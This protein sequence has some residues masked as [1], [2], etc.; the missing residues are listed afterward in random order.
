MHASHLCRSLASPACLCGESDHLRLT[1]A[2]F[3]AL[4]SFNRSASHMLSSAPSVSV[5]EAVGAEILSSGDEPLRTLL[6]SLSQ[7]PS[8]A[9]PLLL[10]RSL[11]AGGEFAQCA[12]DCQLPLSQLSSLS[13]HPLTA[14]SG[15]MCERNRL[16]CA[17]YCLPRLRRLKV[18]RYTLCAVDHSVLFS[19]PLEHLDLSGSTR[20]CSTVGSLAA[21]GISRA[22]RSLLLEADG[23]RMERQELGA[24][25]QN[26]S[27]TPSVRYLAFSAASL[28]HRLR[29][30]ST[31]R[32]LT[33]VD[34]SSSAVDKAYLSFFVTSSGSPVLPCLV[35]FSAA[36]VDF[37][38]HNRLT[39]RAD[40][41]QHDLLRFAH[42]YRQ[43]HT[44][45]L[46]L[47]GDELTHAMLV[48]EALNE[49]Q[50]V[51]TFGLRAQSKAA[52]RHDGQYDS[53][54]EDEQF[55]DEK[56]EETS[57]AATTTVSLT[58][59]PLLRSLRWLADVE[60]NAVPLQD[61]ALLAVLRSCCR[62]R[63]VT[64]RDCDQQTTAAWLL[65]AINAP[66]LVSLTI[67]SEEVKATAAAWKRAIEAFPSL[68]YL[69][70]PPTSSSDSPV[71]VLHSGFPGLA[72][73]GIRLSNAEQSD[74]LGFT[75]LMYLMANAPITALSIHL[76]VNAALGARIQQLQA[77][78]HMQSLRISPQAGKGQADTAEGRKQQQT[79]DSIQQLLTSCVRSR[80]LSQ[81]QHA[82]WL[83][84]GWD[85]ER[86]CD[87]EEGTEGGGMCSHNAA[88]DVL[89][90]GNEYTQAHGMF[91]RLFS[92]SPADGQPL[93][94]RERFFDEL[95]GLCE[96]D[97][98]CIMH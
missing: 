97:Q 11:Y 93:A 27:H 24:L 9:P 80:Q 1:A 50:H 13:V 44:C 63:R 19:L 62:L 95:R 32:Q 2:V 73:L 52:I 18:D 39:Q 45:R 72:Q 4:C 96:A 36:Q 87:S 71:P 17:L 35:Y 25:M 28:P 77:M 21:V 22:L 56:R 5:D 14:R 20:A 60:L 54:E 84:A 49:L 51:R 91:H 78:S 26:V 83:A 94:G 81:Q 61:T 8:C 98:N 88:V 38:Q 76:P 55:E 67:Y 53:D 92:A 65:A 34:L 10:V 82:Q 30:L 69:I 64:C 23:M 46:A 85:R 7:L 86:M 48:E 42:A 57:A 33:A 15:L 59:A 37:I 29:S 6:T 31:I 41:L 89:K 70:D 66:Y 79:A 43:L 75:S 40:S 90:Q 74:T 58:G 47:A 68:A 12:L 16:W 3:H